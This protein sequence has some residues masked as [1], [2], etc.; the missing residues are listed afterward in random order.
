MRSGIRQW[1]RKRIYS[2]SLSC[3]ERQ[4][5]KT[6]RVNSLC[7]RKRERAT[8]VFF[9]IIRMRGG[10][11]GRAPGRGKNPEEGAQDESARVNRNKSSGGGGVGGGKGGRE[12]IDMGLPPSSA[13]FRIYHAR[14]T[15]PVRTPPPSPSQAAEMKIHT[16][17]PI[18]LQTW[19]NPDG[20]D[21]LKVRKPLFNTDSFLIISYFWADLNLGDKWKFG[22]KPAFLIYFY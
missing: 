5:S 9:L 8:N 12:S 4:L 6:L 7:L 10:A 13:L 3:V 15:N 2:N 1:S 16:L 19:R 20:G 21:T 11:R 18:Y 14:F 17:G 22:L